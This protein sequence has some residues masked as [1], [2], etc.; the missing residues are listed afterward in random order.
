MDYKCPVPDC[1]RVGLVITNVHYKTVHGID[2]KEAERKYGKPKTTW[3]GGG[4]K[5]TCY[6]TKNSAKHF[7]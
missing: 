1:A 6:V 2:K 7:L 3:K 5:S 4:K